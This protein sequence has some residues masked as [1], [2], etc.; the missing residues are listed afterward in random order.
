MSRV[1]GALE[2]NDRLREG[3]PRPFSQSRARNIINIE[4]TS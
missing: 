1:S 4:I 3:L 2:T